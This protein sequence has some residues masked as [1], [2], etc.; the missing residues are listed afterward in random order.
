MTRYL[1]GLQADDDWC[2]I[3]FRITAAGRGSH[4]VSFVE[5][6]SAQDDHVLNGTIF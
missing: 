6:S 2:G 5:A 1:E 4:S 3:I